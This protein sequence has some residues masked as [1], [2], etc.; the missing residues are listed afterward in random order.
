[1]K[2]E[3]RIKKSYD[4]AADLS[5]QMITLSTAIITLCVAFTD[6]LFTSAVAQA[7][8][9]WLL[10]SL[11]VFV[12]SISLGVFHLMGLTGQ[13]GKETTSETTP[14]APATQQALR[15]A[16]VAA[17]PS[18]ND[19]TQ[20]N[21]TE[22]ENDDDVSIYSPT[23][24]LTSLFQ[25]LTFVSGLTLALFYIGRS[26]P[27]SPATSVQQKEVVDTTKCIKILRTSEYVILN[28]EKADTLYWLEDKCNMN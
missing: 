15:T 5:K 12:A 10:A 21:Q 9:G 16:E 3:E 2:K 8:S 13:L 26:I 11:I 19:H 7:N 22:S 4:F 6:K 24:R 27:S 20:N 1:M 14:T 23:N 25:V 18:T 17:P 28:G